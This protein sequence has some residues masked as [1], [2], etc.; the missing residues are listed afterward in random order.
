MDILKMRTGK[1]L[2]RGKQEPA[3]LCRPA[4]RGV[5]ADSENT[6]ILRLE[7][8]LD[9][10]KD[11]PWVP[12]PDNDQGLAKRRSRIHRLLRETDRVLGEDKEGSTEPERNL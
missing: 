11:A 4:N 8:F 7:R 10:K 6:A 2:A 5:S 1:L 3:Q 12:Q 9:D